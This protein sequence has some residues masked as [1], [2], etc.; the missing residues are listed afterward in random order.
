MKYSVS[1][2]FLSLSI[3][4][5]DEKVIVIQEPRE[6]KSEAPKVSVESGSDVISGSPEESIKA[7]YRTWQA[8]CREWKNEMNR[9]NGRRLIQA[10]CGKPKRTEE[11][12]Q[13]V[14]YYTTTSTAMFKVR[15]G[16]N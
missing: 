12:Q 1:F 14:K 4:Y 11:T 6:K 2:L 15:I 8:A 7:S 10:S 3:A 5:A 16:G 9:L 13:S